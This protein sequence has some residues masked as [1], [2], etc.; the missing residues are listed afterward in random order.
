LLLGAAA[1]DVAFPATVASLD[2]LGGLEPVHRTVSLHALRPGIP[3]MA[4]AFLAHAVALEMLASAL[5]RLPP[6]PY[7]GPL[8][9]RLAGIAAALLAILPADGPNQET[10]TGHLHEALAV[11]AFLGIAA[12]ALFSANAQRQVPAWKDRWRLQAAFGVA[13]LVALMALGVLVLVAQLHAPARGLYGILERV[14]VVF[15]GAWIVATA[16]Q[17]SRVA[18]QSMVSG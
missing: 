3:W 5:R 11:I 13:L 9:L 16:I 18:G 7:A 6:R 14:A 15:I 4:L 2:L 10:V 8:A 17:G 1:L 12:G